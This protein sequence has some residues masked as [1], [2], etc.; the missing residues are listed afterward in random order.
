MANE[1][2]IHSSLLLGF[3]A[4]KSQAPPNTQHPIMNPDR[5]PTAFEEKVYD[6][7]RLVPRGRVTTYALLGKAI[8]CRSSQAIGQ[9]LRRNPFAPGVACHRII[10]SDLSIGGFGGENEG[11]EIQ[12]KL[13]LLKAEGV[14]FKEGALVE[15]ER[16]FLF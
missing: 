10:R 15:P 9:A 13:R 16:V 1:R 6:A 7:V 14:F 5:P 11:A 8:G 12:R 2:T 3:F 4:T